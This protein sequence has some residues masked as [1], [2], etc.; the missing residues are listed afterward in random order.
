VITRGEVAQWF[1]QENLAHLLT[2]PQQ[3]PNIATMI[4]QLELDPTD[5]PAGLAAKIARHIKPEHGLG[6]AMV[7]PFAQNSCFLAV[8]GPDDFVQVWPNHSYSD[9]E[10]RR[11]WLTIQGLDWVRRVLLGQLTSPV[12]WVQS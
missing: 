7:G 10:Y 5:L 2:N 11:K 1:A 9:D 12:D 8:A 4:E 6:L 3:F